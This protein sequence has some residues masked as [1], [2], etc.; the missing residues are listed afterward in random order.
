MYLTNLTS[1]NVNF[2]LFSPP[3][4]YKNILFIFCAMIAVVKFNHQHT[5]AKSDISIIF[6][7]EIF[8]CGWSGWALMKR[9]Y[10]SSGSNP[11]PPLTCELTRIYIKRVHEKGEYRIS[12]VVTSPTARRDARQTRW[13]SN[14]FR[15]CS[16]WIWNFYFSSDFHSATAHPFTNECKSICKH[17]TMD[18]CNIRLKIVGRITRI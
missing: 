5:W 7:S 18:L 1:L 13:R 2:F 9:K 6:L 16:S 8:L 10:Q 4:V 15:L 17:T 12:R 3:K 11:S 14:S